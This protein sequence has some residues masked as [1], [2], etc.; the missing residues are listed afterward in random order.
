MRN[1]RA[2]S[3]SDLTKNVMPPIGMV[4]G[5]TY[6]SAHFTPRLQVPTNHLYRCEHTDTT[7]TSGRIERT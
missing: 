5:I 6:F 3:A 7:L 4:G 1:S 2:L